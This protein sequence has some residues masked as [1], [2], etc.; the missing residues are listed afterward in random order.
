MKRKI[1]FLFLVLL[2][3][4]TNSCRFNKVLKS[5]DADKKYEYAEKL[6]NEKDYSRALQLF[7]QLMGVT[8]ATEKSGKDLFLL[9]L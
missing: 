9:R 6:Y 3:L 7:D 5:D 4:L 2:A 1:V 8:R